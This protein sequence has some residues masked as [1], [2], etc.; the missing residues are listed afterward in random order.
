MSDIENPGNVVPTSS[1]LPESSSRQ[2]VGVQPTESARAVRNQRDELE[3]ILD[4][5]PAY[6][7]Y[8]DSRNRIL[9]ANRLAAESMNVTAADLEGRSTYD[10]YP[11][12]AEHYYQDD[13]EVIR[14]GQPKL[15]I[16]E[17]LRVGDRK[18]WVST[19]KVPYRDAAGEII[20]VIVFAV[21]ITER[22]LAEQ[23]LRQAHDELEQRVRTRT[24]EL[25]RLA[26]ELR[27]EI[28]E[29]KRIQEN[30]RHKDAEIEH[31]QRVG[32]IESVAA[33]LAHELNQPLAA[34]MNFARGLKNHFVAGTGDLGSLLAAV[35]G[36]TAQAA[37]V[38]DVIVKLRDFVGKRRPRRVRCDVRRVV[39]DAI[40]L[41]EAEAQN[42]A[43]TLRTELAPDVAEVEI[44]PVQIQQVVLNLL[45][46]SLEATRR[47]CSESSGEIL[48]RVA[49][50]GAGIEVNVVDAGSGLPEGA[51]EQI[52][53][54]FYTTKDGGLGMGLA[55]S[56]SI[57]T[58]HGG[59][60]WGHPNV[61]PGATFTFRLPGS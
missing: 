5:V 23:A 4:S 33:E 56:R 18:I 40:A 51:D 9:R 17:R 29:R 2:A 11:E 61:G 21:D 30:L 42:H 13:L 12:E 44:D 10:L 14:T 25:E 20:G 53:R 3:A 19:D 36:I 22:V 6:I 32:T 28:G 55:I 43:V 27:A 37:R 7:W 60:L 24:A 1:S 31:L 38:S 45:R 54:P 50:R 15:G 8:K 35:D 47:A 57:I 41:I 46:N 16:I 48:I 39:A 58:S 34:I 52:F 26:S 49:A 59:K